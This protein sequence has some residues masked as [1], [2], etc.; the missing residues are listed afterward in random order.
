MG[1]RRLED[2][3]GAA[4]LGVLAAQCLEFLELIGRKAVLAAQF[5]RGVLDPVAH[6]IG[7]YAQLLGDAA[8]RSGLAA[9]GD[10][11]D[12]S[13]TQLFRECRSSG[14]RLLLESQSLHNTRRASL[15]PRREPSLRWRLSCL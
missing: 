10:H 9:L 1:A 7:A 13:L 15:P 2:L 6:G 11:A 12:S 3:I 4:Q 8:D 14:H 5:R